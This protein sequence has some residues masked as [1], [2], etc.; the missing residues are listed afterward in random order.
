MFALNKNTILIALGVVAVVIIAV[1]IYTGPSSSF[2]LSNFLTFGQS[3]QQIGQKVIDYINTKNLTG[4][5][6]AELVSVSEESGLVKIKIKIGENE[7]D[8]YATKDGKFLFPQVFDMSKEEAG[9]NQPAAGKTAEEIIAAIKKSDSPLVEAFIVSRCPFGLQM[10]RMIADAVKNIPSLG[11]YVKV[12]YIGSVSG[13]TITAMHGEAEAKENLRQICIRDEQRSKYWDYVSCQMKSGDVSGCEKTAK[14]DSAKLDACI[15]DVKR[16]VAY[17][18]ED[19][20]LAD[21]NNIGGSPTLMVNGAVAEEFTSDNQPVFGSSRSSDEIKTAVCQAFNSKP[22]F[23]S[24]KLNT[25]QA[26][27]SFSGTYEGSG[28]TSSNANCGN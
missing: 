18:K 20:D 13:N 19:F 23:C 10:Q 26:A 16:G 6:P 25:A 17:A 21:E 27:T 5:A 4:G 22:S 7:F 12:R 11:Q 8:S 15:S 3:N 28:S 14:I 24:V 1:L 2:S 9:N